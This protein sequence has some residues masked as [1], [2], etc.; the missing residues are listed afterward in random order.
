MG[1]TTMATKTPTTS[2][3]T[4]PTTLAAPNDTGEFQIEFWGTTGDDRLYGNS[5]DNRLHGDAGD[6]ILFGDA[7][8]D[9][10]HGGSGIDTANY[11][12]SKS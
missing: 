12:N 9:Q 6:D 11:M 5:Y 1:N 10:L 3:A 7:G 8:Y 4:G 2:T